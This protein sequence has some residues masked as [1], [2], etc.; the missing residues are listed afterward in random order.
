MFVVHHYHSRFFSLFT[1]VP[2]LLSFD[3]LLG[4]FVIKWNANRTARRFALSIKSIHPDTVERELA[5][6]SNFLKSF[7]NSN[8]AVL[9]FK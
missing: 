9:L 4:M 8:K 3:C 1:F 5:L 2:V 6:F 7:K